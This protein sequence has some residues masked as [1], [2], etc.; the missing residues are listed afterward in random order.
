[1]SIEVR[2]LLPEDIDSVVE[3]WARE[4]EE[5]ERLRSS[6]AGAGAAD[7]TNGADASGDT[8]EQVGMINAALGTMTAAD[9]TA[10]CPFPLRRVP[11]AQQIAD[12]LLLYPGQSLVAH[13]DGQLVGVL[14]CGYDGQMA[15]L[16]RLVVE[17][18]ARSQGVDRLLLDKS[19]IKLQAAGIH[20]C[21]F[22]VTDYPELERTFWQSV[23]W[24]AMDTSM[25][26]NRRRPPARKN[27][28]HGPSAPAPI[29]KQKDVPPVSAEANTSIN[30]NANANAIAKEVDA[31]N[32][33]TITAESSET[34]ASADSSETVSETATEKA[35]HAVTADA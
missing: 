5:T 8:D 10:L 25:A 33:A 2:E 31:E 32:V 11:E 14:L 30:A 13:I 28:P 7:D 34:Q 4:V 27:V 19:L 17:E 35:E 21:H 16:H 1:M 23:R 26:A 9:A 20:R 18:D 3:L 6:E 12:Y 29:S 24:T 22:R 15:A